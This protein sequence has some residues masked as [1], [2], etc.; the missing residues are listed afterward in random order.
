MTLFTSIVEMLP[1][2]KTS[3]EE[4]QAGVSRYAGQVGLQVPYTV[5]KKSGKDAELFFTEW[6]VYFLNLFL[7]L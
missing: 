2:R 7:Y 4:Q 1:G 3:R 6:S 5:S